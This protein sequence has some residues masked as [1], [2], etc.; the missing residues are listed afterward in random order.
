M[1]HP[2]KITHPIKRR[3]VKCGENKNNPIDLEDPICDE[4]YEKQKKLRKVYVKVMSLILILLM[5][6]FVYFIAKF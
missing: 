6:G 2:I 5:V 3:C 1:E 4:C